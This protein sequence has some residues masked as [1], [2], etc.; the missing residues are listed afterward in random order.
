MQV[1]LAG[2]EFLVIKIVWLWGVIGDHHT[3]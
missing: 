1:T 3:L 2:N